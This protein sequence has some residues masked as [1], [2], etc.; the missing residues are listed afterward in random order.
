MTNIRKAIAFSIH[1]HKDQVRRNSGLPYCVHTINVFSTVYKYKESKHI[2][3]L[4]CSAVLHDVLED[5]ECT[6]E[7]L[8]KEYN[9]RVASIC[10]ELK[11]DEEEIKKEIK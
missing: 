4:L 10:L 1:A 8:T 9:P 6:F 3:D 2:D 5:T 11:N 7:Y